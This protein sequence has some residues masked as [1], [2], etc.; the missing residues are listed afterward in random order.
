MILTLELL[1]QLN[2]R[3]VIK[4]KSFKFNNDDTLCLIISSRS[5]KITY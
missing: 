1:K 2:D 4:K 3:F 5:Y